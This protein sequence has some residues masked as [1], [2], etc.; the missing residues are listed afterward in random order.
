MIVAVRRCELRVPTGR[1]FRQE[2]QEQ[3]TQEDARSDR[4]ELVQPTPRP[5]F[6]Q[7]QE[8]AEHGR[9]EER[10]ACVEEVFQGY[11]PRPIVDQAIGTSI[12]IL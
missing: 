8:R 1:E 6:L 4:D 10:E 11:G 9:A 2:V 5:A 12:D 3:A 7:R